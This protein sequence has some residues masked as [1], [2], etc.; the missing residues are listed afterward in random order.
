[1]LMLKKLACFFAISFALMFASLFYWYKP[2]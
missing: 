2:R 1:L